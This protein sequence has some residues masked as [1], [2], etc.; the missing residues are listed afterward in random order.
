MTDEQTPN[1]GRDLLRIHRA[2]TRAIQVCLQN[3]QGG[4]PVEL[5]R[6]GFSLYIRTLTI[7][8]HAH[9][10]GEE[11]VSFPFWQER[12]PTGPFDILRA[13]HG[14]ITHALTR[15][16]RW[17]ET[18]TV[19]WQEGAARTLSLEMVNLQTLW[20]KHI[21]LEEATMGPE[22]ANRMLTAAENEQLARQLAEHGQAHSQPGELVM[23]FILFN[24]SI[25][26]QAEFAK[27]LPPAV[28]Q[29]LIPFAWKETWAPMIPFLLAD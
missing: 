17:L 8:L 4:G 6:P 10:D 25:T 29:Q 18:N 11:Q 9:H 22:N 5:Q 12:L 3:S 1:S 24:L 2:I 21:T 26:D 7:L 23:P 16:E 15:I 28:T 19:S 14:Q 13:Q 27:T 20:V